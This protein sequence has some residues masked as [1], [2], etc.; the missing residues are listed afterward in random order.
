MTAPIRQL[1]T[2]D[3]GP[4]EAF[5]V[6]HRDSSMFL[7]A[8]ARRAGLAYD[9]QIFQAIYAAAFAGE[10]IVGVAGHCWNGMLLLQ[11][12]DATET[13]ARACVEMSRREVTG[14]AGPLAQVERAR[15][16]LGLAD[17]HAALDG[18]ERMYGLDLTTF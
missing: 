5:L 7:R 3:A 1:T 16:A 14:L 6:Q 15:D 17:R 13:I 9:G 12:P 2:A 8:N 10:R 11:A 4:L 18:Q